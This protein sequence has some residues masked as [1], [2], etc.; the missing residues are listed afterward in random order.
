S[1]WRVLTNSRVWL[2]SVM[3]FALVVALYSISFWLPQLLKRLSGASDLVVG[4]VSALP[5]VVAAIGMVYIGRHSDRRDERRWHVA[6]P[7]LVAASGL[8]VSALT[9][10]PAVAVVA[11]SVAALGIWG[12]LGP[13][14]AMPTAILRG[15]AAAAGIAWINS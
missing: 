15:S 6:G 1:V 7:A 10:S 14:W 13:F 4:L 8:V 9:A 12:A 3:Y 2:F 11:I 5:Y